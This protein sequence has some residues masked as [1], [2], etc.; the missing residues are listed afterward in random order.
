MGVEEEEEK[1]NMEFEKDELSSFAPALAVVL[2]LQLLYCSY[3][4]P[5]TSF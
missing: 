1:E 2:H 5:E 3:L 4:A